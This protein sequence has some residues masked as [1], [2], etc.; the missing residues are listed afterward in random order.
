MSFDLSHLRFGVL[1]FL[2]F[3]YSDVLPVRTGRFFSPLPLGSRLIQLPLKRILG[4]FTHI[5]P[6]LN[7]F[8][9]RH[10]RK[11]SGAPFLGWNWNH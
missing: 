3:E 2:S 10:V 4:K 5:S 11:S 7:Q 1:A 8:F 9:V 6:E